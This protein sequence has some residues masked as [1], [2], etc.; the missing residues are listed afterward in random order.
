MR[1]P[2]LR[3]RYDW[4]PFQAP[5]CFQEGSDG[6]HLVASAKQVSKAT[7]QLVLACQVKSTKRYVVNLF[8]LVIQVKAESGSKSM[9]GLKVA[10]NAV[11]KAT[12]ELVKA[13]Q[14]THEKTPFIKVKKD[15]FKEVSCILKRRRAPQK[16]YSQR[17]DAEAKVLK[18]EQELSEAKALQLKLTAKTSFLVSDIRKV[19]SDV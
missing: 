16:I 3:S 11:R 13:A 2:T 5:L 8:L 17:I 4:S 14:G 19:G 10:S 15:I 12:D 9:E 1:P 7:A 18:L 6:T